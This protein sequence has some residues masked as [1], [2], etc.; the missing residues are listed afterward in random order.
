MKRW[1]R[2]G[3]LTAAF[4]AGVAVGAGA[5]ALTSAREI[6]DRYIAGQ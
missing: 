1:Y 3:V 6:F 5:V 4:A 2:H